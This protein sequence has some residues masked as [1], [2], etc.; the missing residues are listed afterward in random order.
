MQ[1]KEPGH[2][3]ITC[4]QLYTSGE[5]GIQLWR[6]RKFRHHPQAKVFVLL[7]V[8]GLLGRIKRATGSPFGAPQPADDQWLRPGNHQANII[9]RP[10]QLIAHYILS[11]LRLTGGFTRTPSSATLETTGAR[12]SRCVQVSKWP[13]F[14]IPSNR[15]RLARLPRDDKSGCRRRAALFWC[16]AK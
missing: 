11:L 13:R 6:L 12:A 5:A 2:S 14:C 9:T 15:M 3:G 1:K 16:S 10:D 7:V 4:G 8:R